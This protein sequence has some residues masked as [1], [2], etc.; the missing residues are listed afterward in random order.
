MMGQKLA[1]LA[2]TAAILAG[3]AAG[4]AVCAQSGAPVTDQALLNADSNAGEWLMYG[5]DYAN[6]RFSPL[7]GITPDNVKDLRP[8]FAFSTGGKLGGLE[9]TPL[10]YDGVLYFSADDSRVFAVNAR[11]GTMIW[12][13]QPKFAKGLDAELCCGPVNRGVA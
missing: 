7:T 12:E 2:A 6:Q 11:T 8:T 10:F 4:S 5:R 3:S 13:F 1:M 9:A